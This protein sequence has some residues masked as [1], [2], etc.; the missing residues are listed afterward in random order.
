MDLE[1]TL[2]L[3]RGPHIGADVG[4]I[5]V[6]AL[7]NAALG[8]AARQRISAGPQSGCWLTPLATRPDGVTL[9]LMSPTVIVVD[10]DPGLPLFAGQLLTDNG[11]SVVGDAGDGYQV[12]AVACQLR[13]DIVLLDIQVPGPD[14]FRVARQ[15]VAQ[16]THPTVMLTSRPSSGDYGDA[17]HRPSRVA[18]FHPRADLSGAVLRDLVDAAP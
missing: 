3:R 7:M 15:L 12:V 4:V 11:F 16:A 9:V 2:D 14:G 8:A 5:L 1:E 13:P 6:A 18:G 17:V 10:D